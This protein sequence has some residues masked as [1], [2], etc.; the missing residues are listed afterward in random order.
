MARSHDGVGLCA[1]NGFGRALHSQ[2]TRGILS[3][4]SLRSGPIH[5]NGAGYRLIAERIAE[6]IMP[7]IQEADR[8]H[9][10]SFPE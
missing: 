3:D 9:G 8:L 5:P 4:A 2:V 10:P 1:L 7:L 6:K